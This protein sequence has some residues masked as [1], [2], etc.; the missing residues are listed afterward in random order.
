VRL[1]ILVVGGKLGVQPS[2]AAFLLKTGTVYLHPNDVAGPP[3]RLLD[4]E[5]A[6]ELREAG[7]PVDDSEIAG[8]PR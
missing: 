5:H 3:P 1:G 8:R 7:V 6:A 4:P 2:T